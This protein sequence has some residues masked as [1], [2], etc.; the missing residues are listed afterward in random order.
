M[1]LYGLWPCVG[2]GN[3]LRED[4][5][6][7]Y[8]L[9]FNVQKGEVQTKIPGAVERTFLF[10]LSFGIL[11]NFFS[12]QSSILSSPLCQIEAGNVA[13]VTSHTP[14]EHIWCL[15]KSELKLILIGGQ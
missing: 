11:S 9:S 6:Y 8:W 5:E 15:T 3:E 2:A 13:A 7:K 4:M 1:I 10:C 14:V 12:F